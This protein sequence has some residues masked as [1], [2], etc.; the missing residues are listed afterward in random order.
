MFAVG[1]A[2]GF[3]IPAVL[4]FRWTLARD[5][6]YFSALSFFVRSAWSTTH[7]LPV[8]DPMICGG[9]NV[10]ANPQNR[11]FSPLAIFDLILPA[12]WANLA[13]LVL[14]GFLGQW[15]AYRLF[16]R[17]GVSPRWALIGSFLWINS[18]WFGLHFAE[19][20]VAFGSMQLLP[21]VFLATLA[22]PDPRWILTLALLLAVF[23]LDGGVYTAIFSLLLV[24][25]VIVTFRAREIVAWAATPARW[26]IGAGIFGLVSLPKTWPVLSEHPDRVPELDHHAYTATEVARFLFFPLNQIRP[27]HEYACYI[28]LVLPAWLFVRWWRE[29]RGPAAGAARSAE[30][31]TRALLLAAA[32]WFFAASGWLPQINP[33]N[34]VFQKLPLLNNA[35]LQARTLLL[36][37]L[38][39]LVAVVTR[40][41]VA[42]RRRPMTRLIVAVMIAEGLLVKSFPF[43]KQIELPKGP[44]TGFEVASMAGPRTTIET[45]PGKSQ[46]PVFY[47]EG[48]ATLKRCYEPAIDSDRLPIRSA[49]D[50]SYRGEAYILD[51]AA[52]AA[53][54]LSY[55]PGRLR[56]SYRDIQPD[57][58]SRLQVNTNDLGYW[59]ITS[60]DARVVSSRDQL[61]TLELPARIGTGRT[62]VIELEFDPPYVRRVVVACLLGLALAGAWG[63]GLWLDRKRS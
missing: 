42:D 41:S 18:N 51:S 23:L 14:Y 17:F 62:T 9:V 20:H 4:A 57:Q 33:W 35:H 46:T 22:L 15:G 29:G 37:F 50:P 60:G 25:T 38:F 36:F 3:V 56:V 26:L 11:L 47:R 5:W 8:H 12:T 32:F 30:T 27:N 7:R 2:V 52:G 6:E 44:A 53:D 55:T 10:L 21:W 16:Q 63:F 1:A 31:P 48:R 58:T 24:A 39:L 13:G 54:V 43:V 40:A 19:G 49:S 61:L 59:T 45:W 28:G 34:A